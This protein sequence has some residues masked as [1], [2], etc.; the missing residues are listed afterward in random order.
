ML[1]VLRICARYLLAVRALER[2]KSCRPRL[3]WVTFWGMERPGSA[4]EEASLVEVWELVW[5]QRRALM[6]VLIWVDEL[7]KVELRLLIWIVW[8]W[9]GR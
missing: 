9:G 2:M 3:I 7:E 8:D 1:A 4:P 5:V 6:R